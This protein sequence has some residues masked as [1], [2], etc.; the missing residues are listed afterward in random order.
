MQFTKHLDW[1][2]VTLPHDTLLASFWPFDRWVNTGKGHHGY[3][4]SAQSDTFGVLAEFDGTAEMGVHVVF[5]GQTL[6]DIRNE[7][8]L[9][10]DRLCRYIGS[11]RGRASRVDMAVNLHGSKITPRRA[12][13]DLK[14]GRLTVNAKKWS[15]VQGNTDGIA[16]DTLYCGSRQSERFLRIYDKNAQMGVQ[17]TD[18]WLRLEL[19][20]KG[21]VARGVMDTI[22]KSG[23][24]P[25]VTG[26]F[27]DF[28]QWDVPEWR[29]IQSE[30]AVTPVEIQRKDSKTEQWLLDQCV[31][32]LARAIRLH[33]TFQHRFNDRLVAALRHIDEFQ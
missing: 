27:D 14:R 6:S 33:P 25:T 20:V 4:G 15:F 26:Y 29:E 9:D 30:D 8:A 21:M 18:A 28:L 12:L 1:L 13:S 22:Q 31:P 16:G 7:T 17:S 3:R 23:T 11:H 32:A 19:E 10:D 24:Q 2:S 5:T